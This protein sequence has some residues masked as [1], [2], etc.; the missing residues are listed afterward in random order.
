M[1][2]DV[3]LKELIPLARVFLSKLLGSDQVEGLEL[4]PVEFSTVRRRQPDLV[5]RS[6]AGVI[7]HI[8]LQSTNQSRMALRVA[9][10]GLDLEEM[11][12]GAEIDHFV[13]SLGEV[14]L[15]MSDT[16]RSRTGALRFECRMIDIRERQGPARPTERLGTRSRRPPLPRFLNSFRSGSAG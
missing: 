6:R 16:F 5:F 4:L 1:R 7:T 10:Y 9:A 8:E 13:L 2:Y 12:P 14:P 15:R 11:Y 3:A